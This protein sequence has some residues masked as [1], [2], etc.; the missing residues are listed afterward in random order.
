MLSGTGQ[1][2]TLPVRIDVLVVFDLKI[3]QLMI[4]LGR[5]PLTVLSSSFRS[6][7]LPIEV[8][9][10]PP[11]LLLRASKE[12]RYFRSLKKPPSRLPWS[13]LFAKETSRIV[14]GKGEIVELKSFPAK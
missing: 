5:S 10:F 6:V 13:L 14:G 2:H 12:L 11:I 4:S 7:S 1:P 3:D 9:I 8:G